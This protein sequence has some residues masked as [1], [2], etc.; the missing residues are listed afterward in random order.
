MVVTP[1]SLESSTTSLTISIIGKKLLQFFAM[2]RKLSIRS[3]TQTI[4]TSLSPCKFPHNLLQF[5]RFN[6]KREDKQFICKLIKAG[7]P[8]TPDLP[9]IFFR[10]TLMI[11]LKTPKVKRPSSPTTRYTTPKIIHTKPPSITCKN[12]LT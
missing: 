12:N 1:S 8:K 11:C 3:G 5:R 10:F 6:V 7:V 2:L 9:F 4:F